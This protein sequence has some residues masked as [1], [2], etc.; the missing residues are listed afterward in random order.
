MKYLGL[1]LFSSLA[2]LSKTQVSAQVQRYNANSENNYGI[3]YTL[4]K[5]KYEVT[6]ITKQK[7]FTPGTLAPW[8]AKFLGKDVTTKPWAKSEIIEVKIK[9]VGVANADRQYLVAFDKKTIAPFVSLAPGGI[10]YSINGKNTP[11]V[12]REQKLPN[13]P[14]PDRSLPALPREYSLATTMAKR[15]EIASS[16]LYEVRENMMNIVS[17]EV[18]QMPKDGESMRLILDKLKTEETK[19]LRLFEGDTTTVVQQQTLSLEPEDKDLE[20]ALI[21]FSPT[22]GLQANKEAQDAE[23]LTLR[24]KI[25]ERSPELDPKEL[26]RREKSDGIVYNLPGTALVSLIYKGQ[27][28]AQERLPIT[29]VGT[30]QTMSKKMLNLKEAGT[31]AIYFDLRSGALLRVTNE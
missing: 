8:A 6:I 18:D 3:V 23:A 24:I 30:I 15:A 7:Q 4:P 31:T 17:G 27:E 19:T 26:A 12:E 22:A 2:L 11:E 1:L 14:R 16:Y 13:Y 9:A 25:V 10:I 29:Q 5:T 20:R 28:L 21:Y